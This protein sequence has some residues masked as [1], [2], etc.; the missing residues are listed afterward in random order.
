MKVRF[1]KSALQHHPL[2]EMQRR[3]ITSASVAPPLLPR[4]THTGAQTRS[5]HSRENDFHLATILETDDN[6]GEK[7]HIAKRCVFH[8]K[9]SMSGLVT[10]SD[11]DD[12]PDGEE[13]CCQIRIRRPPRNL[14]TIQAATRVSVDIFPSLPSTTFTPSGDAST[15]NYVEPIEDVDVYPSSSFCEPSHSPEFY[16]A[17][18]S[19]STPSH[20]PSDYEV[21]DPWSS[22]SL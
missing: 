7:G 3:S 16:S 22:I 12:E 21:N 11:S 20:S 2:L 18:E 9:S 6:C 1:E 13:I 17:D 8:A 19:D 14:P 15:E 10:D 4:H 5:T